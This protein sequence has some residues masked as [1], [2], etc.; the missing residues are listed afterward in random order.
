MERKMPTALQFGPHVLS[1][2]CFRSQLHKNEILVVLWQCKMN[3]GVD[4]HH[5]TT[6]ATSS[7]TNNQASNVGIV[8]EEEY[9]YSIMYLQV[10]YTKWYKHFKKVI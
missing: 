8:Y 5:V 9:M 10:R 1:A 6:V 3:Q 7:N 2:N 4:S